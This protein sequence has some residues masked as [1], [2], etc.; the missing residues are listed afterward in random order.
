[1]TSKN[2]RVSP[3]RYLL[4]ED[5]IFDILRKYPKGTFLEIGAGYGDLSDRLIRRGYTGTLSE[6]SEDAIDKL[7]D[8]F[9]NKKSVRIVGGDIRRIKTKLDFIFAMEVFEHIKNDAKITKDCY[10][11]LKKGGKLI[12]SVPG[13]ME[14]WGSADIVAGHYRRYEFDTLHALLE[15]AQFKKIR[16]I[17]YGKP[18]IT[19]T[20]FFAKLFFDKKL[21]EMK[22]KKVTIEK[23]TKESGLVSAIPLLSVV[24]LNRFTMLPFFI[25]QKLFFNTKRGTAYLAVAE[26]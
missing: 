24:I 5:A 6:I 10:N 23:R 8:R 4:R 14:K 20:D 19:L 1:M 3:P 9:K 25:L 15:K 21:A 2:I 12:I 13:L 16:I 11:A 17:T 18:I 7:K 26:K 22:D